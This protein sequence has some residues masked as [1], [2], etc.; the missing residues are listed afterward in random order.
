MSIFL[1]TVESSSNWHK[2]KVKIARIHE[3]IVN[4]RSDFLQKHSTALVKNH[5]L[6]AVEDL[7]I[8]NMVKNHKLAKSIQEV[9]WSEFRR[10]LE[11]KAQM[12]R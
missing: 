7:H 12:V 6:I 10:M 9:S 1:G 4:A 2:Q 3:R 8:A 5:D 11:Y